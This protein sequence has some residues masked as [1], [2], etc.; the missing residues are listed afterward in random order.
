MEW[1]RW[2]YVWHLIFTAIPNK[3]STN[4]TYSLDADKKVVDHAVDCQLGLHA[5]TYV[6]L[7]KPGIMH[8]P[9]AP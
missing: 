8:V 7:L 6:T 5:H 4:N 2:F 3:A 1:I 9:I